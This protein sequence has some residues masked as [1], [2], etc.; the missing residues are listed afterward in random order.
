MSPVRISNEQ[1]QQILAAHKA[2]APKGD[3]AVSGVGEAAGT[4]A[5][6]VSSQGQELQRVLPLL[7]ALPDTRPDR[8]ADLKAR[9]EAGTYQPTGREIA[10][11]VLKRAADH[12]L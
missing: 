3:A 6:S 10:G 7:A 12:L 2:K 9:V 4:D 1:V 11:S 8:V 5:L